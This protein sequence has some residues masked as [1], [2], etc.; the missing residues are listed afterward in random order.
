M[1]ST[2][3]RLASTTKHRKTMR[4]LGWGQTSSCWACCAV[5]ADDFVVCWVCSAASR[6]A[7]TSRCAGRLVVF[8]CYHPPRKRRGVRDAPPPAQRGATRRP[9][10]CRRAMSPSSTPP[11]DCPSISTSHDPKVVN[12]SM[13]YCTG[14]TGWPPSER[15]ERTSSHGNRNKLQTQG[16]KSTPVRTLATTTH[17]EST[18]VT[19]IRT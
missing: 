18:S 3:D 5:L 17:D 19:Y 1:G 6:C 8:S 15:S 4:I 12:L 2:C 14:V 16:M 11:V 10:A 7:G 13:R 9:G